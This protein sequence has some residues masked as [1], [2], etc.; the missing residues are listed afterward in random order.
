MIWSVSAKLEESWGSSFLF[1]YF[2]CSSVVLSILRVIIVDI[3]TKNGS[4]PCCSDLL[5]CLLM[6]RFVNPSLTFSSSL[7]MALFVAKFVISCCMKGLW[8][9]ISINEHHGVIVSYFTHLCAITYFSFCSKQ[10]AL[11]SWIAPK[12]T[13]CLFLRWYC[14]KYTGKLLSE[15]VAILATSVDVR[16]CIG[17]Q[18][19][20]CSP[21]LMYLHTVL[22]GCSL[23]VCYSL[24]CS[25]RIH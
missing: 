18:T 5:C 7:W 13:V 6:F 1:G 20:Q 17:Q 12:G 2:L 8:I 14:L 25:A 16:S 10:L 19:R 11:D 24:V 4:L 9:G 23:L 3:I 15:D 21:T 22:F